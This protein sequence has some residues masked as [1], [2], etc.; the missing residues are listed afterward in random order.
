MTKF[1]NFGRHGSVITIT[2]KD[3]MPTFHVFLKGRGFTI[4]SP[5][6]EHTYAFALSG[7]FDKTI[8][9]HR[10]VLRDAVQYGFRVCAKR[11]FGLKVA[12]SCYDTA[13]KL[14]ADQWLDLDPELCLPMN[15]T[16]M[17]RHPERLV[18]ID[19]DAFLRERGVA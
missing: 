18:E 3:D 4:C 16:R 13:D 14:V 12:P 8:E 1:S 2:P 6:F 7:R 5:D 10:E 11:F 15:V 9:A 17:R 19:M